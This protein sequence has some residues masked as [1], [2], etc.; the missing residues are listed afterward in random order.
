MSLRKRQSMTD[1]QGLRRRQQ[2]GLGFGH[3]AAG[4]VQITILESTRFSALATI[5]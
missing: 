5:T 1:P 3:G 4:T 2:H